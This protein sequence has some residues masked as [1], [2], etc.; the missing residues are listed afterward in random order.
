MVFKDRGRGAANY[1]RFRIE[2]SSPESSHALVENV[3]SD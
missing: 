1:R 3:Q 2:Q